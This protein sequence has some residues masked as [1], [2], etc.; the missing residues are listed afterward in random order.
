MK[1]KEKIPFFGEDGIGNSDQRGRVRLPGK[2]SNSGTFDVKDFNELVKD[3]ASEMNATD[4]NRSVFL[5]DDVADEIDE[6]DLLDRHLSYRVEVTEGE[7][8]KEDGGKG[9]DNIV[10][11]STS[12]IVTLRAQPHKAIEINGPQRVANSY[13]ESLK[14]VKKGE[15]EFKNL[16]NRAKD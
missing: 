8:T 12:F 16:L 6:D 7:V 2:L 5:A 15:M 1:L 9:E 3:A 11:E 4:D 14:E 13:R 10:K